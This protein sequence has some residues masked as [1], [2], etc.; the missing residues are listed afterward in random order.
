MPFH[1]FTQLLILT[2]EISICT[3]IW[4]TCQKT[5]YR[6]I[7]QHFKQFTEL[8]NKLKAK[9]MIDTD[10]LPCLSYYIIFSQTLL[11]NNQ[12]IVFLTALNEDILAVKQ[13]FCCQNLI[14]SNQL[15]LIDRNAATLN[16]FSHLTL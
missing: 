2:I 11:G 10:I 15:F 3:L 1:T 7:I 9:N 14:K 8:S 5:T 16:K 6:A 12:I 4:A 13:I